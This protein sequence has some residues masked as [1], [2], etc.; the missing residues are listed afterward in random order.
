M[1]FDDLYFAY[2]LALLSQTQ[3]PVHVKK[4]IVAAALGAVDLKIHKGKSNILRN[5]TAHTN[6]ITLDREDWKDVKTLTYL[7]NI[8]DDH[9]GSD[10]NVKARIGIERAAYLQLKNICNSK[11]LSTNTKVRIFN[12]NV[13]TVPLYR[14]ETWRTT[15][16]IIQ[17]IQVFILR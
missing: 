15:K 16:A 4:T 8:S 5:K 14:A 17:K 12:T 6:R 9:S 11:Q 3:Q 10:A 7:G 2:D 1:Q 13:W